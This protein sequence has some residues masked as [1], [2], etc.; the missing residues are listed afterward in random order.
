MS[1]CRGRRGES[2]KRS[3]WRPGGNTSRRSW[4]GSNSRGGRLFEEGPGVFEIRGRGVQAEQASLPPLLLAVSLP[5]S[6]SPLPLPSRFSE[7]HRLLNQPPYPD[8]HDPILLLLRQAS[9]PQEVGGGTGKPCL[10]A[11]D[12]LQRGAKAVPSGG[13]NMRGVC[14]QNRGGADEKS[15]S[16]GSDGLSC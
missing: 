15:G 14:E 11:G 2:R 10:P 3:G 16:A 9:A 4:I 13:D 6:L 7:A 8:S 5:S 1:S 12:L